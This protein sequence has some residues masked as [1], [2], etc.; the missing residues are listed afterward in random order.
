[1]SQYKN[2]DGIHPYL[3][4]R[5]F[6]GLNTVKWRAGRILKLRPAHAWQNAAPV[7][8]SWIAEFCENRLEEEIKIYIDNLADKLMQEGGWELGYLQS[9]WKHEPNRCD[10]VHLLENWPS[11]ADAL[12]DYPMEGSISDLNALH[13]ILYSGYP[14]DSIDENSGTN[15]PT[16]WSACEIYAVLAMMKIDEA[17]GLL[18]VEKEA[19]ASTWKNWKASTL[20]KAGN[21]VTE[22]MEIVC[23]GERQLS[24]DQLRAGRTELKKHLEDQLKIANAA[25]DKAKQ[26]RRKGADVI[27]KENRAMKAEVY[28]WLDANRQNY[29]SMD[30]AATAITKQQPIKFRAARDWVGAWKKL[31]SASTP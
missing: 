6:I 13:D 26:A 17:L 12:H 20:I 28:L 1:M 24:D 27:H 21:L 11:D 30:D 10:I 2:L 25:L 5:P 29:G 15:E 4:T 9:R 3:L 16:P 8:Q 18:R 23:Y 22:A 19:L 7:L 14:Y 31:R